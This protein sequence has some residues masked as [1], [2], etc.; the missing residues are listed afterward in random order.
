MISKGDLV[1]VRLSLG[2]GS[3]SGGAGESLIFGRMMNYS[4]E[5]DM[6]ILEPKAISISKDQV[7]GVDRLLEDFDFDNISEEMGVIEKEREREIP[8]D[9]TNI[10]ISRGR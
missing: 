8:P 5:E 3:D 4:E 2:G 6:Y 7:A 9:I 10:R 1:K